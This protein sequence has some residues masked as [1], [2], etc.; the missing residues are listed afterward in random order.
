MARH[1]TNDQFV[2]LDIN[3]DGLIDKCEFGS[4]V[5]IIVADETV[6]I[7]CDNFEDAHQAIASAFRGIATQTIII[8]KKCRG[9]LGC[10]RCDSCASRRPIPDDVMELKRLVSD[11]LLIGL[12]LLSM[13]SIKRH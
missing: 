7:A 11:W 12:S 5:E 6:E 4:A 9:C 8:G 3:L 13:T 2:A 1:I 10:Y